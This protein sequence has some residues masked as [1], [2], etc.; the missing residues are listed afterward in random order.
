P[1]EPNRLA[2]ALPA[3]RVAVRSEPMS[4]AVL[5]SERPDA[6]I[7]SAEHVG[8]VYRDEAG[9]ERVILKDVT[10]AVRK[11]ETVAVLGPSGCGKSTPLRILTGLIP[12]SSG[13]VAQHGQPLSGIHPGAAVVF[14]NFALFPW[15]T[16]EENVRVG[17]NG[18]PLPPA[19]V[20]E[21]V[22]AAI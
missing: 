18:R 13:T 1:V 4:A 14:Q 5:P 8:K 3:G 6:P 19:Q 12:P 10:F 21:K 16:V 15:L 22:A 17:L 9:H 20:E 11:G 2:A 7:A